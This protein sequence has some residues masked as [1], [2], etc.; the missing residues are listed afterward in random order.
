MSG[1]KT[2]AALTSTL[3][4]SKGGAA[5]S[6]FISRPDLLYPERN[7]PEQGATVQPLNPRQAR[8]DG[9]GKDDGKTKVSL[10]MSAAR[11]RRL[12]LAAAHLGQSA[13]TL[14]LE[15]LDYYID[16]V[17]PTLIGGRCTCMELG[18][19][20]GEAC[21]AGRAGFGGDIAS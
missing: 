10:R 9:R 11:H 13:Q 8:P 6:A 15:G 5:P 3:L 18:I 19:E 2:A 7:V 4:C 1:L 12:R 20:R 14:V 17:L 21:P 16:H